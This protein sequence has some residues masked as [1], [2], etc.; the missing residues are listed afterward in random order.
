MRL[1]K[2]VTAM[3]FRFGGLVVVA[4]AGLLAGC[5]APG[6][7]GAQEEQRSSFGAGDQASERSVYGAGQQVPE[8]ALAGA[9][10]G[11]DA[12]YEIVDILPKDAI[13]AIDQPEFWSASEAAR[14]YDDDELVIGVAFDGEARAYSVSHL[15]RHEI[16]NDMV[17]GRKISVT[18]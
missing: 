6:V 16:V 9:G 3:G 5:A 1:A 18:W 11:A 2:A 10:D 14:N 4:A 8:G 12:G 17:G 13:P 15:S 7:P